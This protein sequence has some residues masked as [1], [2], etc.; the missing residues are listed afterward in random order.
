MED[1]V[2]KATLEPVVGIGSL[3]ADVVF[4][5]DA[6]SIEESTGRLPAF[7]DPLSRFVQKHLFRSCG[8][9]PDEIWQCYAVPQ[10][11]ITNKGTRATISIVHIREWR[12][13]LFEQL[14]R[15]RPKVVVGFGDVALHTLLPIYKSRAEDDA[16]KSSGVT[17]ISHWRGKLVWHSLAQ[18]WVMPVLSASTLLEDYSRGLRFRLEQAQQ[19]VD[20]ALSA[21][22]REPPSKGLP[23]RKLLRTEGSIESELTRA[24]DCKEVGLDLETEDLDPRDAEILGVSLAVTADR[25]AYIPM[26]R[27]RASKRCVSLFRKLL[28]TADVS[29]VL[30]NGAFDYRFLQFKG[31]PKINNWV[32]TMVAASLLDENFPK[33][34]KAWTWRELSFGGYDAPLD[35]YRRVN[36]LRDFRNIPVKLMAQYAA[37]DT[38]A[39][40]QLWH[41]FK[42]QLDATKTAKLFHRVSMPVRQ[43][44][45]AAEVNG[46]RVDLDRAQNLDK[47]CEKAQ[48]AL[49]QQ[50]CDRVGREVNLRS[51]P[52][53]REV[54]F[55]Q[56]KLKPLRETKSGFSVDKASLEFCRNQEDNEGSEIARSLLDLRYLAKQQGTFINLVLS[57]VW[58]DGRIHTS[59]NTT[60]T[61]TGRTSCSDPG[62]HNV[63]RDR[64][65]RSIY[66]SSEGCRLVSAD[67]KSAELRMLAGYSGEPMLLSAFREGRDLHTE[68]YRMMFGKPETYEPTDDERFIAKAINFGLVYGRGAPSL[69]ATLKVSVEEAEEYIRI[70]FKALPR[71]QAWLRQN[72]AKA[73]KRGYARSFFGRRRHLPDLYNDYFALQAKASRQANNSPIQSAAADCTYVGLVRIAAEIERRRMKAKLV[74]TVHDCAI[75][76]VPEDEVEEMSQILREQFSRPIRVVPVQLAVDVEIETRWGENKDSRLHEVLARAGLMK[77][78][79]VRKKEDDEVYDE[80]DEG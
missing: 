33:G 38:P 27:L 10:L 70:Y 52:Q 61:V 45:S 35:E 1:R 51:T 23:V 47:L 21:V 26:D 3:S 19:D 72:V 12:D 59:Y 65:I 66:I 44:M 13:Y 60:G 57:H 34:L 76:D 53:L 40:L 43:V 22:T 80:E 28:S 4:V 15:I 32:D 7:V 58:D 50:I 54:L 71:A 11:P 78:P 69:A 6:P 68:V 73:K 63:P 74:H 36:K 42:P 25:G 30:H 75:T 46:F 14:A 77:P 5:F 64:L 8:I 17:G 55:K 31:W 49:T 62:I 2:A 67:I 56:Y 48:I 24:L 41:K 79:K 18:A 39:T 20:N 29:K 16:K 9:D 37:C